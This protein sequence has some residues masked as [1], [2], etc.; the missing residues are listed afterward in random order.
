M[1]KTPAKKCDKNL[2]FPQQVISRMSS[3]TKLSP[4]GRIC[5][6]LASSAAEA[7]SSFLGKPEV[8]TTL[9]K[10]MGFD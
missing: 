6:V 2:P 9:G 3:C 10:K 4:S 5:G 7:W 8:E 1:Y